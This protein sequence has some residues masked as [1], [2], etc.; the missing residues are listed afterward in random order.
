MAAIERYLSRGWALF[1]VAAGGKTP[2]ILSPHSRDVRC[3]GRVDGCPLDGHGCLDATTDRTWIDRWWPTGCRMNIGIATGA[4]S[5]HWVL[6]WDPR[7]GSDDAI[8]LLARM[9][10]PAH[11]QTGRGG[12][13]WRFA[14]PTDFEVTNRRGTLPPGL[15]VRGTGGY[16]VAPPSVSGK[17]AYVE[18]PTTGD[19]MP[20]EAP[21][22]LLDMIRPAA[23]LPRS[24]P[25]AGWSPS[26]VLPVITGA[27]ADDRGQR[28]AA[29]AVGDMLAELAATPSNR[30]DLAW[31]TA[32]RILEFVNAGDVAER[33]ARLA[34]EAATLAHP[35]GI[36]VPQSEVDSIWSSAQ[37]H[38]GDRPAELPPEW[39][40]PFRVDVWP[41]P[42]TTA[43]AVPPFSLS[44]NGGASTF[45]VPAFSEP[46]STP[47]PAGSNGSDG[48]H[49]TSAPATSGATSVPSD[50]RY[51]FAGLPMFD[52]ATEN[53]ISE[54]M[55]LIVAREQATE[56]LRRQRDGGAPD[57]LAVLRSRLLTGEQLDAVPPLVP[58]VDG[59][60]YRDSL[61]RINGLPGQGKSFLALDVGSCVATGRPW[62]GRAVQRAPVLYMVAEGLSGVRA[63]KRAWEERYGSVGADL[64]FYAGAEQ[65]AG[66]DWEIFTALCVELGAGLVVVDTQA[67]ATA[68]RNENLPADMGPVVAGLDALRVATG[69]C[70]LLIHHKSKNGEGGR[71]TNAVEG[72]M[73]SEFDCSKTGPTVTL[74]TTRQKD[75]DASLRLALT[76]APV[77]ESAVLVLPGEVG[78]NEEISLREV[79][80]SR[81]RALWNFMFQYANEGD[82]LTRARI[83]SGMRNDPTFSATPPKEFPKGFQRAWNGLIKLG[84]VTKHYRR[85]AFKI[86]ELQDQGADGV[87]TPNG[88]KDGVDR[89]EPGGNWIL[90]TADRESVSKG[91]GD[92]A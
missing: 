14:L 5:D 43:G 46:G 7:H 90:W 24:E 10:G 85:D 4:A 92:G 57:R 23:P 55:R 25:P 88:T 44:S 45:A 76:L 32:C 38:V 70:V 61:A 74:R 78:P 91:N 47:L 84:L 33:S 19:G 20:Y 6:D 51:A 3:R 11:V 65:I 8:A 17:G 31:R 41:A 48:R 49:D 53:K 1:P 54:Q 40:D 35:L 72:A 13:H 27:H 29:A 62:H 64:R 60:L 67:R 82:G 80:K 34:W 77:G 63:R 69:A 87:L 68:G 22:W 59:M 56:R 30:N 52:L 15:D 86:V 42:P 2:A 89:W 18:L 66:E 28:Y 73:Q 79:G 71:G 12:R 9:P 21:E 37:R 81:Q 36:V 58:I 83:E 26:A 16:V 75:S 50:P 39:T